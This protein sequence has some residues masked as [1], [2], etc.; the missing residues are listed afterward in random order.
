MDIQQSIDN[1]FVRSL[2][3]KYVDRFDRRFPERFMEVHFT[4]TGVPRLPANVP[5]RPAPG[6][7]YG[8]FI[9]VRNRYLIGIHELLMPPA[10][11]STFFH[12]YGHAVYK[13]MTNEDDSE[14]PALV[15]SE[16]AAMLSSL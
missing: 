1:Q 9:R 5:P 2:A 13:A 10:Q 7:V 14:G 15:R 3:K 8:A 16:I 4:A 6:S 12:E 11:L